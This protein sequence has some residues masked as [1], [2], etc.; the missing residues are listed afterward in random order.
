MADGT[1]ISHMT[2]NQCIIPDVEAAIIYHSKGIQS[3]AINEEVRET[4]FFVNIK[5]D[6]L[7]V[8]M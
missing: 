4:V 3:N 7:V 2:L 8:T 6:L 1:F 5:V